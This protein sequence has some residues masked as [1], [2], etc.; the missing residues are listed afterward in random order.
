MYMQFNCNFCKY[1]NIAV[2]TDCY[3]NIRFI[4]VYNTFLMLCIMYNV[5]CIFITM[6]LKVMFKDYILLCSDIYYRVGDYL[7]Y[8]LLNYDYYLLSLSSFRTRS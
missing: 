6:T 1:R 8:I 7:R 3:D 4:H 5:Y 2:V